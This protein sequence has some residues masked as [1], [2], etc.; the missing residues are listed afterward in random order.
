MVKHF[1]CSL[2]GYF[3][4]DRA[5]TNRFALAYARRDRQHGPVAASV[6]ALARQNDRVIGIVRIYAAD[7]ALHTLNTCLGAGRFFCYNGLP[8]VIPGGL[9]YYLF[10]RSADLASK[11][12]VFGI[13]TCNGRALPL[14]LGG[15]YCA[16]FHYL[17]AEFAHRP[18]YALLTACGFL[19]Y[20]FACGN[21][22]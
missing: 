8:R 4:A 20:L 18:V 10:F 15:F 3:T 9:C 6:S 16:F 14:M 13:K 11:R 12:R 22:I 7:G 5:Y 1:N 17:A 19:D 21:M 2:G